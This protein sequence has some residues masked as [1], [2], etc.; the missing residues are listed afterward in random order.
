MH[1]HTSN[2][3]VQDGEINPYMYKLPIRHL[4]ILTIPPNY[5]QNGYK[6]FQL[7]DWMGSHLSHYV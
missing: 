2:T 6:T 3:H 4:V 5:I 1:D 7:H